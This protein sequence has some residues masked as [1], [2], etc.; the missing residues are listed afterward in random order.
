MFP[1]PRARFPLLGLS[2]LVLLLATWAGLVRI[3]WQ[4]PP[5]RPTLPADHG[6]LMVSGF[7]GTLI[8]LERAVA[9][10]ALGRRWTY[11]APIVTGLG[12][13]V[14]LAHLPFGP[15][16]LTLGS[17]LL[18]VVFIEIIRRQPAIFTI[19]MGVGALLW[20]LGN[21]IWLAG[22]CSMSYGGG[23]DISC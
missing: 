5:L 17:L 22:R 7:L 2:L 15:L 9:L 16:L 10:A 6:P 12:A 23:A 1:Q 14:T 4:L 19:I 18:V 20:A 13:L 3:G 8:C 21:G 11:A